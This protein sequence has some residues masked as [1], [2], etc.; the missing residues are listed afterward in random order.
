M[1]DASIDGWTAPGFEGVRVAFEKN[2]AEG[3]EV[4]AAFSAYHRGQVVADMWGGIADPQTSAPWERD[5]IIGV[6]STTKGATAMCAHK[7]AQEGKLDI[8]APVASY[9]PEFAAEGKG[10]IP[11]RYLL[12]HRAGLAWV[13]EPLT[14]E[15]A[16]AWEPMIHALERQKPAWEPG[17]AHGYHAITYG[18]L[19]GE[20]IR[21][22]TG[23]SV[24]TYFREEIAEPLGLDFWIGL[25][26][27]Q[28]S[29]V[30]MLVG[31]LTGGLESADLDE[32]TRA[33]IA[34]I[35]GP[36][37][38]MGKALSG[39]GAFAADGIW[40]TR[41]VHAAEVPAAAGVSDARSIARLYAACVGEV[42]GIRIL[43]PE[44][45][46]VASAQETEGPNT[47]LMNLDLQFGLGFIVPSSLVQLGGPR[48]FGHFGAGGSVGW[49]DPESEFG[50]G[51]VMSRM[52]LGLAGDQRSS[53]LVEACY[54]AIA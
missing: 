35:M 41:A 28:E 14:L 36:D 9:W 18:Y 33:S 48:S 11:V 27:E 26:E 7:L 17:T 46:A 53:R 32:A 23:R 12:S 43:T 31:S 45:V 29:R 21:R 16:L 4:G 19:V 8:D 40:N 51:Y 25:P 37:S 22:I 49:A 13:D 24:G 6:F 34:A 38:V 47:V 2:F 44:R 20:V 5:T 10:D 1:T 39:G 42:D 3:L 15:Q 50:F 54:D 52:D 30:A